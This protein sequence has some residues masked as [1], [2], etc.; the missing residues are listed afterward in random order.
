MKQIKK[1]DLVK[2]RL[3]SLQIFRSEDDIYPKG[4]GLVTSRSGK[5]CNV[6][7]ENNKIERIHVDYLLIE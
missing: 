7:W 2:H 5:F 3:S 4:Y 1:G 6:L